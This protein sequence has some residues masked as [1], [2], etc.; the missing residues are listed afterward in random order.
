MANSFVKDFIGDAL[1]EVRQELQPT[2]C[3]AT[4]AR[5]MIENILVILLVTIIYYYKNQIFSIIFL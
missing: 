4:E 5:I 1:N 2:I 3:I